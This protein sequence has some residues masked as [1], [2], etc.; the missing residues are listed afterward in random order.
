M[1]CL[2]AASERIDDEKSCK[3]F[4]I[5]LLDIVEFVDYGGQIEKW[6]ADTVC[7]DDW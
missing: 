5:V 6:K 1:D 3:A 4:H 2:H 7:G